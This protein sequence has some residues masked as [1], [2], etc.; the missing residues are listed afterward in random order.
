MKRTCASAIRSTN[1][2]DPGCFTMRPLLAALGTLLAALPMPSDAQA[3]TFSRAD[4]YDARIIAAHR[5]NSAAVNGGYTEPLIAECKAVYDATILFER[6]AQAST[7]AQRTALAIAKSLPMMTIA[8]GYA[9][10]DGVMSA[11]TCQAIRM[12][13]QPLADYDPAAANGLEPFHQLLVQTRDQG[14]P[15]CRQGGHWPG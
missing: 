12:M 4:P 3:R 7:P 6:S 1:I 5:C 2:A 13:S 8:A 11:R 15:K 10:Q 14:I 9:V